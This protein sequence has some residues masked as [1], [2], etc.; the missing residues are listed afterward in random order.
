MM[1]VPQPPRTW[2]PAASYQG[3]K[4]NPAFQ[5]SAWE[6]A[7]RDFRVAAS[8][9]APLTTLAERLRLKIEDTWEDLGYV[10][11]A[12]F[13]IGS[14]DFALSSFRDTESDDTLIWM[15]LADV[16]SSEKIALLTSAL[17]IDVGLLTII[18]EQ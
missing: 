9:A 1:D 15:R 11:V 7:T 6:F 8:L 17:G 18:H 2:E 16:D 4:S 5:F 3:G 10:Q 14:V 13:K 12:M